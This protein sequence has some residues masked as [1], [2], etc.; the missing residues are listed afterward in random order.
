[1]K[2]FRG[3]EAAKEIKNPVVTIGSFDGVHIG[4]KMLLKRLN[5]LAK[6]YDG[7]SVV[8]TFEPHPRKVLYPETSGKN[9]QLITSYEEKLQLLADYGLDNVIV[10]EFTK[11]LSKI[12]SEQFVKEFLHDALK[13]KAVVVGF[14]HHFGYNKDGNY[15]Q[16]WDL[17]KKYDFFTEEIPAQEIEDEIISSVKIRLAISEGNIQNANALLNHHYIVAGMLVKTHNLYEVIITDECKLLPPE[18]IYATSAQH[19]LLWSKAMVIIQSFS[20]RQSKMFVDIFDDAFYETN[21]PVTF[22]FHS[23]IQNKAL[24]DSDVLLSARNEIFELLY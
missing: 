19:G 15:K 10:I 13:V 5:S 4:H 21:A 20:G 8:I 7:E 22:L 6:Q 14:N 1:M 18:G 9:L 24:F 11:E 2:I 3:F 17:Q 23:K 12:T 16:L